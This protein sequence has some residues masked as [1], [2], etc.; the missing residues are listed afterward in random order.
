[1]NKKIIIDNGK[2]TQTIFKIRL[3]LLLGK[4][5]DAIFIWVIRNPSTERLYKNLQI[6]K[7]I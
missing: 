6:L 2:V 5:S 1:M 7:T 3:L 4:Y